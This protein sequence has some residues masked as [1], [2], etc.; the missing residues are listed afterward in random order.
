MKT[1]QII[2]LSLLLGYFVTDFQ[3]FVTA[4]EPGKKTIH[5]FNSKNLDGWYT[6]LKSRGKDND[7]NN[8]F[9]VEDGA[10]HVSGTEYGGITTNEE[11]ENYVL[12][13]EYKTGEKSYGGKKGKAFDSGILVHSVGKD[14]AYNG[15]WM[16][17]IEIQVQ[18]GGTGNFFVVSDAKNEDV[19]IVSTVD[20]ARVKPNCGGWFDPNGIETKAYTPQ[21]AIHRLGQDREWKDIANFRNENEIEKPHGEWNTIKIIAK[22]DT[23]DV[24][25]NGKLVN[26]GTNVKPQKGRIQIQSEGSEFFYR[27]IDL[28]PF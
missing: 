23:L 1:Y 14:G 19:N 27:Q 7:I 13:V 8:V 28:T 26:R 5:L 10:I 18:E 12:E 3:S 24:Y 11:Y 25:L 4:Q 21:Q 16:N 6:F 9:S 17:S 22:G 15:V 2:L 20:P